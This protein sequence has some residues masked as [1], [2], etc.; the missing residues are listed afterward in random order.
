MFLSRIKLNEKRRETMEAL[1]SPHL[2][3]SAVDSSFQGDRQRN[4]WRVDWLNDTC[5][6]L[7]LSP[8]D[9]MDFSHITEKF[10]YVDMGFNWETKNYETLLTRLKPGQVWQ[11]RLC[12]NPVRSSFREKDSNTG[13]GKVFA[14]VTH[15]QQK[16]W[17]LNRAKDYGF[18]LDE[19]LFDVVNSEWLKFNKGGHKSHRI[20]L[21][22]ASFEG[23]LTI[24]DRQQFIDALRFG[25]GRAKAYGCG[26]MTIAPPSLRRGGDHE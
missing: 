19:S 4:L 12:A 20:S 16:Q 3:H 17:L 6:L 2:L 22:T 21:H 5:Y 8:N 24:S 13:R 10:G 18:I 7:V 15:E 23:V 25:I 26:L 9:R 11:F 1:A 14:H